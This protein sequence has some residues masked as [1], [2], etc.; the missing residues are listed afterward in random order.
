MTFEPKQLQKGWVKRSFKSGL[1]LI[2]R[3]KRD[4]ALILAL[5]PAC[6]FLIPMITGKVIALIT[7]FT[8]GLMFCLKHDK[9]QDASW[10]QLIK[11]FSRY[12]QILIS[13]LITALA[14]GFIF[15][16][17]YQPENIADHII[18]LML[19]VMM[20]Y[21]SYLFGCIAYLALVLLFLLI[22]SGAVKLF[23]L[24]NIDEDKLEE[25][26]SHLSIGS[27]FP[28]F[29]LFILGDLGGSW[30]DADKLNQK[31]M[32]VIRKSGHFAFLGLICTFMVYMPLYIIGIP[33]LY[34]VYL[35][36]FWDGKLSKVK[37]P[38]R[39]EH[40]LNVQGN[41]ATSA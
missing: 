13:M 41:Q 17:F 16:D 19:L 34:G 25:R 38:T 33:F 7:C 28:T 30:K 40:A 29:T 14:I 9:H 35:E 37:A 18:G 36:L 2:K 24:E 6:I 39:S 20:M 1:E 11:G 27:S 21:L 31:A 3:G 22:F 32:S 10:P 4:A 23:K 5:L 8:L 12:S 26:F 15:G